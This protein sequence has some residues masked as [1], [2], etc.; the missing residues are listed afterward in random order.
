M[1]SRWR[2]AQL[3]AP[4]SASILSP[5]IRLVRHTVPTFRG[6]GGLWR[7]HDALSLATPEAFA[8]NPS[9]VWQFY[10]YRRQLCLAAKPNRAH[11]TLSWLGSS[12]A[13]D[14]VWPASKNDFRLITQNVDGLSKRANEA[15]QL[16]GLHDPLEMHGSLFRTTCLS[17]KDTRW[18]FDSP[19]CSGLAGTEDLSKDL[20]D[21]P[22]DQ[23]PRCQKPAC[24]GL[25]RPAVVWFGE[26]IPLLDVIYPLVDKCDLLLVLGTS[27]TVYPAAG[28]AAQVRSQGGKVAVFNLESDGSEEADFVF[29]G[30][31]EDTL[32]GLLGAHQA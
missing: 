7:R 2:E 5:P 30:N 25:L 1:S 13:R 21:L 29:Q 3:R 8:A 17:C 6:S 32:P 15:S 14:V 18:N 12:H 20:T 26:S 10:H 4:R 19:I 16:P 31:V 9:K 24:S 22:H 11:E 27:S 23:L 28:L